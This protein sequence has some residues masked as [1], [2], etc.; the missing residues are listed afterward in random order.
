[1]RKS[2][3]WLLAVIASGACGSRNPCTSTWQ[4]WGGDPSH[5]GAACARG[6]SLKHVSASV[7]YDSLVPQEM[8]DEGGELIVHYQVPLVVGDDVYMEQK[9]GAY[10]PCQPNPDPSQP[11]I[12]AMYRWNSQIWAESAY[13][14]ENGGLAEQWTFASDWKPP[15]TGGFEPSFQPVV[16]GPWIYVPGAGG[17]VYKIDRARGSV[18]KQIQP[19]PPDADTYVAGGL[20]ADAAGNVLYDV[21]KLDHDLPWNADAHGWLVEIAPDDTVK[22]ADFATLVPDAPAPTDLC[23]ATFWYAN[24]W[25]A[26]PWPPPDNA[27]GSPALPPD[28]PCQSQRPSVGVAPAVGPD[29]TI[30]TVSRSHAVGA[31]SWV[32]AVN[33]DLTPKWSASMRDILHDGCGDKIADDG[34]PTDKWYDCAPGARV[35]VDPTTNL[36]PAGIADGSSSSSPVALPDGG[37]LYGAFTSYNGYRGHLFKFDRDGRPAGTFDFGWDTT[38]AVWQHDGTYSIVMK[39]NHYGTDQNGVD[40]GP[41]YIDQLDENLDVEWQYLSV[42]TDSCSRDPSSGVVTC[43]SNHPW[44]FE[45]CVNAAAVDRDGTVYVNSEDG[46]VYAIGQ[47]GYVKEQVFL[48]LAVGAA[49]TPLA[50]DAKGRIY[51]LNAGTMTVFAP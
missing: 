26:F 23:S 28:V 51:S 24:P 5:T 25:P 12:C 21:F 1:M 49:Y 27:D 36:P 3:V 30:F 15:P 19:F 13:H 22:T 31:Y 38:P 37:V 35:G 42:N 41:Y 29:G 11:P 8:A 2:L 16:S 47:G 20:T 34:D 46:N 43:T 14:V 40:L 7:V 17:S 33:P 32:V 39:D 9:G 45:W 48:N 50:I 6:A 4:Q 18:A 10:T 44:G